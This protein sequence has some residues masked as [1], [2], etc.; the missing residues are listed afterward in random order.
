MNKFL[1][2]GLIAMMLFAAMVC[3]VWYVTPLIAEK[4]LRT[5]MTR[6]DSASFSSLEL[7]LWSGDLVMNDV[8]LHDSSG[9]ISSQPLHIVLDRAALKGFDW[10]LLYRTGRIVM[11]SLHL[12]KG[13][14]YAPLYRASHTDGA[15]EGPVTSDT[16]ATPT[17]ELLFSSIAV[18]HIAID[19]VALTLSLNPENHNDKYAA[20]MSLQAD[21]IVMP[22]ND[23]E[24]LRYQSVRL[25]VHKL[26]L[27][28]RDK[29]AFYTVDSLVFSAAEG[30]ADIFGF[31]LN[32]R[33]MP[34]DYGE[35]VNSDKPHTRV[36]V[37]HI[38]LQGLPTSLTGL[39]NGLHL[40]KVGVTDLQAHIY[41]DNR[42]P[43]TTNPK[44]FIGELLFAAPLPVTVDE[45]VIENGQ[46][47]LSE[48]W[49]DD[50]VPGI[51]TLSEVD[52]RI[53]NCT[54]RPVQPNM[55][56]HIRGTFKLSDEFRIE[57]DWRFDLQRKGEAF[58]L[59]MNMGRGDLAS[60]NSFTENTI[61]I[62]FPSGTLH[63][64][65][66]MVEGDKTSGGGSLSLFY[67]N[68]KLQFIDRVEHRP[69]F[70]MWFGSGLA[71]SILPNSNLRKANRASGI[72]YYEPKADRSIFSYAVHLLLSGF[73]DLVI[74]S[75]NDKK[76]VKRGMLYFS[77]PQ[78]LVEK[79]DS[80]KK[81]SKET[82]RKKKNKTK[83]NTKADTANGNQVQ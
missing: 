7:D 53:A 31:N 42:Y 68:L 76:L 45:V 63:S 36:S 44:P 23:P 21:S 28:Q 51:I 25:A 4:Q 59:E 83:R 81:K 10:W 70:K 47:H 26:Y 12:G 52:V 5:L 41:R 43:H 58:T 2:T 6:A 14:V 56:T 46:L 24:L 49:R 75:G 20:V 72:C 29:L 79:A 69:T 11:D 39:D 18:H 13:S 32:N 82:T 50:D 27:Q 78:Q 30:S 33:M 62:R 74:G 60:L 1:N 64:A 38:A 35:H 37:S 9:S 61:G 73:L 17:L 22:L 19:S 66:M 71:N 65:H 8:F 55:W 67:H 16:T 3:S 80:P 34:E 15:S 77:M 48:N 57:L 54:N 40:S